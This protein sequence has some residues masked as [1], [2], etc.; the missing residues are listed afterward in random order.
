MFKPPQNTD[1]VSKHGFCSMFAL[2]E[3][4][5]KHIFTTFGRNHVMCAVLIINNKQINILFIIWQAILRP[6]WAF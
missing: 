2:V 5:T 3:V 1:T 4:Q 6:N